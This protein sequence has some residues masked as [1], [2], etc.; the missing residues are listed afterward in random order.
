MERLPF[1]INRSQR[2]SIP[3]IS[4]H[5]VDELYN[6]IQAA[7]HKHPKVSYSDILAPKLY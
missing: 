1:A 2:N 4:I 3:S 7:L 6:E 5:V